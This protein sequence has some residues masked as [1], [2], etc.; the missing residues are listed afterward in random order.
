MKIH[1]DSSKISKDEVDI[2]KKISHFFFLNQ[3]KGRKGMKIEENN[4]DGR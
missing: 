4:S 1:E 3:K 2:F